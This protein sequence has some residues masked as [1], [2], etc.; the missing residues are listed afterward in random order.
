[1]SGSWAQ[2]GTRSAESASGKNLKH[3]AVRDELIGSQEQQGPMR[4]NWNSP[5]PLHL[6]LSTCDDVDDL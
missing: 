2:N 5:L 6:T 1:M 3:E 4:S